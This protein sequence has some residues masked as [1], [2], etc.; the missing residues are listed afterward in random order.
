M[1]DPGELLRACQDAIR[2]VAKTTASVAS[3]PADLAGQ[4]LGPL[5][6]QAELLER[7]VERQLEFERELADRALAPARSVLDLVH[8][9]TAGMHAEAS[10]FRMAS[11]SLGQVADLLEQQAQLLEDATGIVRD[12][13]AALRSAGGA[14]GNPNP[15]DGI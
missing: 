11:A 10:A 1:A 13:L 14:L 4:V 2:E 5:Q 6:R 3:V 15:E 8:Q 7:V 9:A 12:P